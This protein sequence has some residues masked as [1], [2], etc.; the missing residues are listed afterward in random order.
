MEI[1]LKNIKC[2]LGEIII[3]PHTYFRSTL[4]GSKEN[5][6]IKL[7]QLKLA[8]ND[9]FLNVLEYMYTGKLV[10]NNQE[11]DRMFDFMS[12][13]KTLEL[14]I[15]MTEI[16]VLLQEDIDLENVVLIYEQAMHFDQKQLKESCEHLID[17]NAEFLVAQQ[18]M[19]KLPS[20]CLEEIISRDC[21]VLDESK[22]FELVHDWH[23]N[24]IR[25][26]PSQLNVEL[27]KRIRFEL[28]P[29]MELSNL[30][31][32]SKFI[33]ERIVYQIVKERLFQA[34]TMIPERKYQANKLASGSEDNSIKI[35]NVDSGECIRT[36]AGHSR[37][38]NSLQ[39]LASNMLVSGSDDRS[40]KIWNIETGK[41]IGT[42]TGHL[43]YVYALQV[44]SNNQLASASADHSIQIWNLNSSE[45]IRKL[46]GH[47]EW[48][49]SLQLLKNKKLASGSDDQS[50]KIWNV[51]RGECIRTLIGHSGAV[52]SLQVLAKNKM[53]SGSDDKT[54][55]I[56][57]LDSG[58]CIRTLIGHSSYVRSLQLISI[59]K[60]ASGSWDNS[61]KIW[62]YVSGDCL[63]TFAGHSSVVYG[64]QFLGNNKLASGS[65]DNSIKI[66]NINSG[67]CIRT[68]TGHS[69]FVRPLQ[70]LANNL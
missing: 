45:S 48:V 30:M 15:L 27:I 61:I 12:I 59:F 50:I 55:K 37:T 6:E 7:T 29:N 34:N 67:E 54:I 42:L 51:D 23:V 14:T 52:C 25:T 28:I 31:R 8:H 68:L 1:K 4:L 57:N 13:A 70:L 17:K 22:V 11:I 41:C 3:N 65:G 64:L 40:I 9:S 2:F 47:S 19:A 46:T 58:E 18:S 62:N 66:W 32:Q 33:N 44:L 38:I 20:E 49:R 53:A 35:W 63:Q 26:R 56:W 16:S 36:L 21:F 10:L 69:G 5:D 60:L 39:L 43:N 24:H